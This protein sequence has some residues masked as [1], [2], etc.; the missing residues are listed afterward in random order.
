MNRLR[1]F[2]TVVGAGCELAGDCKT[3]ALYDH[4]NVP[5]RM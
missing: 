1:K 4:D 3:T 2:Y 5:C